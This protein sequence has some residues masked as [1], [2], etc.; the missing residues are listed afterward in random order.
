MELKHFDVLIP[1]NYFCDMIFSGLPKFPE[2]GTEIYTHDLTVVPGG[3]MNTV[4][5]LR[6]L[7]V[8]VGWIGVL[9]NDFFSRFILEQTANEHLDTSLVV[10]QDTDLRRVTVALSDP[11]D[12]AF[13]TYVDPEADVVGMLLDVWDTVECAHLH[14]HRLM[15]DERLIDVLRDCRER[16]IFVSMDC[17]HRF[18]TLDNPLVRATLSLVNVFMPNASEAM[19]LTATTQLESAAELLLEYVPYLVV[20]D[21]AKGV[22]AWRDG[23]YYRAP[24]LGGIQ[25][26]DTTGAGDV[27]NAGFLAACLAKEDVQTCLRW[28]NISGGLS[29]QGYGGCSTAPTLTQLQA[30]LVPSS[31]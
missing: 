2:M 27:F 20:K 4:V 22:H 25:V 23:V 11:Q 16:G 19:R 29:T 26:L 28:G 21:G 8:K 30:R 24:A 17:Q 3:V 14:F 5:A 6:R 1:G 12:R 31:D 15:V 10:Q 13:I 9:G 18:E 7:Q